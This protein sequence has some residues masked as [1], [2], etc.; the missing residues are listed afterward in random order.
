MCDRPVVES[1][2]AVYKLFFSASR[3][4]TIGL[5]LH[6]RNRTW[7]ALLAGSTDW[8]VA[9]SV[10]EELKWKPVL[11][12]NLRLPGLLHCTQKAGEVT[13]RLGT[14]LHFQ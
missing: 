1:T 13:E 3:G 10:P 2:N 7:A 11:E 9:R 4:N 14:E 8:Y 12:A 5:P 6:A